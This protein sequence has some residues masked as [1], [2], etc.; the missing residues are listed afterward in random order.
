MSMMSI[1]S[2]N[3]FSLIFPLFLKLIKM[4]YQLMLIKDEG[5][6]DLRPLTAHRKTY[7]DEIKVATF[8]QF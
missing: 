2:G 7:Q 6:R 4:P 8:I 3:Y 1:T 5:C